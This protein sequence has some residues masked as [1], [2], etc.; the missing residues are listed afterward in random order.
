MPEDGLFGA[1]AEDSEGPEPVNEAP[2]PE[3]APA[4]AAP[5]DTPEAE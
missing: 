3:E 5:T 2:A 1:A 4:E